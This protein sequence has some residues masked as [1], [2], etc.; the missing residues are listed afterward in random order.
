MIALD[1]ALAK[2]AE[3]D[4]RRSRVAEL[5][6]FGGLSSKDIAVE[7]DVSERTVSDDWRFAKAWLSRELGNDG[8]NPLI[9]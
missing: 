9:G 8:R 4:L 1:Q 2:L 3:L 7:V 6:L 5:K